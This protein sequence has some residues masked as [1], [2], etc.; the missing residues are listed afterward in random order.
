MTCLSVL[1]RPQTSLLPSTVL[2]TIC[3]MVVHL[4]TRVHIVAL[5][6][7]PACG[8]PYCKPTC[9]TDPGLRPSITRV[10]SAKSLS[11]APLWN[12]PMPRFFLSDQ[13]LRKSGHGWRKNRCNISFNAT[14]N[15]S[16]MFQFYSQSSEWVLRHGNE[17]GETRKFRSP[18]LGFVPQHISHHSLSLLRTHSFSPSPLYARQFSP[19]MLSAPKE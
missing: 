9:A 6:H 3:A 16:E 12:Q 8:R 14:Q 11:S 2:N 4:W 5:N 10:G 7:F 13:T 19:S 1:T 17:L 15:A 18:W